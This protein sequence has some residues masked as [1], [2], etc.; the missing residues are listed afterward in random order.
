MTSAGRADSEDG[1]R[2]R[3]SV[4]G[5]ALADTFAGVDPH[6]PVD[7]VREA[8]DSPRAPVWTAS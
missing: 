8:F 3:T 7:A 5:R 1:E 2:V 4:L 6:L